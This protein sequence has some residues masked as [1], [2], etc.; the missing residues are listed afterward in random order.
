MSLFKSDQSDYILNHVA[1]SAPL[2]NIDHYLALV[3]TALDQELTEG[4]RQGIH[5]LLNECR[6]RINSYLE[7][8]CNESTVLIRL[9]SDGDSGQTEFFSPGQGSDSKKPE[10]S[11]DKQHDYHG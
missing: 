3:D 10:K 1:L 8:V 9:S 5:E 4:C 2:A 7:E 6:Y 11:P